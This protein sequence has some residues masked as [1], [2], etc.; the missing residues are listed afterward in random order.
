MRE[1]RDMPAL[2]IPY[3]IP[4]VDSFQAGV[5]NWF[6]AKHSGS[7]V[8]HEGGAGF[9]SKKTFTEGTGTLD[10]KDILYICSHGSEGGGAS[11]YPTSTSSKS[12]TPNDLA[13]ILARR[14]LSTEC[15]KIESPDVPRG[16]ERWRDQHPL[17]RGP[18][19][20]EFEPGQAAP[21]DDLGRGY[22]WYV[23]SERP[24]NSA[25]ATNVTP[26]VYLKIMGT[27]RTLTEELRG[28][29]CKWFNKDGQ[30][31]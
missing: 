7:P 13:Q 31:I 23:D 22:R 24:V 18:T 15:Q 12:I 19:G 14:G 17:L 4:E 6:K 16:G 10:V 20:P 26:S 3:K 1:G 28:Q 25:I 2:F 8:W 27:V 5:A 21:P 9:T 29:E 30:V 11:M